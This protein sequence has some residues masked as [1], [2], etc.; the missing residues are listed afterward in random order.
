MNPFIV[1]DYAG[2]EYFCDRSLETARI[3]NAI[4]NQRN[5]TLSS[6]RK[7]GK[8]GLIHH[9]F[10]S[11]EQKGE[12]DT[13]YF[14]VYFTDS[15]S[16]FINKFG[17]SLLSVKETFSEKIKR[18]IS[19]FIRSIRPT[20]TY[21]SFSGSP[22]FSFNL[23]NESARIR[24]LDEI[25]GF[26][27]D[28][29]REKAIVI[30]IDEFQQIANY[31][32]NNI[33]ALL[34][35]QI[36]KMINVS[37]I[38]SGSDKQML[39]SMFADAKRPFYQSTEFMHLG[40][41]PGVEYHQFIKSKFT[42][43]SI[44]IDDEA[45]Q[46]IFKLTARHTYYVQFLCNKL[47]GSGSKLINKE[48]VIQTLADIFSENEVYYGEYREL[49]TKLQWNLLIAIAKEEGIRKVTSA[50][51]IKNHD[52]SNNATVRRGIQSLLEKNMIYKKE[53][54]FFVQ[55]VFFAMWLQRL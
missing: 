14:D 36:Q 16:G 3:I 30:A 18:K 2:P 37:F 40:E 39:T 49:L 38:F 34:R 19:E 11:L 51:F 35:S 10:N 31:P 41:I 7:M 20:I 47:F 42:D 27:E 17:T 43:G 33:E 52:L 1:K 12:I 54:R 21:D 46:E 26:L 53:S 25:F 5:L 9:V 8:T 29:S 55:D 28:R 48:A 6:I 4:E 50:A 32:E 44:A 23:E 24:T 15:L 45:I 13:I 22:V